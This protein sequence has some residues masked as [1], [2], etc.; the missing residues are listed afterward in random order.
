MNISLLKESHENFYLQEGHLLA[1]QFVEG[2]VCFRVTGRESSNVKPYQLGAVTA[3]SNLTSWDEIKDSES[4]R[5]LEPPEQKYIHHFFYGVNHPK[6][7]IFFQYPSRRDRNSLVQV[8]RTLGGDVGYIDGDMSPYE[9]PFS[10]K[11]EFVT[12]YQTYPAFNCS[13]PL[14][15]DMDNI[16]LNFDAMRYRYY[17]IKDRAM[18][19]EILIGERRARKITVGGIDPSPAVIPQWLTDLVTVE[20]LNYTLN[21][22]EAV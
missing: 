4:R 8:E 11:S 20:I 21:V 16:L 7:R 15:D 10:V 19:R 14:S 3:G 9:G 1:L 12:V 2:W 18:I 22:M 17:L 5:L 13:N 6:A